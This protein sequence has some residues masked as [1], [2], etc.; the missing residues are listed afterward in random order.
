M[1]QEEWQT[2]LSAF[3]A[4]LIYTKAA[5]AT[6]WYL[7][8]NK[9]INLNFSFNEVIFSFAFYLIKYIYMLYTHL[10][11]FYKSIKYFKP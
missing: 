8:Q 5:W 9:K 6:Q 3:E 7:V 11:S 10:T 1:I 4:T 2:G